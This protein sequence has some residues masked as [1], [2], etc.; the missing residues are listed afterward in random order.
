M[1]TAEI[2]PSAR[3][4]IKALLAA[5]SLPWVE[6]RALL[7]HVTGLSSVS[8]VTQENVVP[9][10]TQCAAY[11]TLVEQRVRGEPLAY[12]VGEREFFSRSFAVNSEVLIPRPETELLVELALSHLA[13]DEFACVL[14]LG[15][16]SGNIGITLA[17][18]RPQSKV[19]AT[20]I[21]PA[22]LAVAK[23]N[24]RRLSATIDFVC[25]DWYASLGPSRYQVIVSNPPYIAS[26]DTHLTQGDLR[27]EPRGALCDGQDGLSALEKVIAGSARHLAPGG[28]IFVEHGYDQAAPVR[29]RLTTAGLHEVQSWRDLAGIERAS[30]G[31]S[32]SP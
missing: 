7:S 19:I 24:A 30:G 11:W 27:F 5:A 18:E 14:D 13:V 29:R 3:G 31:C 32:R 16:G 28:W 2:A 8:L 10:M 22:A 6:R 9:S 26:G 12:L 23:S 1:T 17:L 25:S 21:A 4:S 15:T 20:D